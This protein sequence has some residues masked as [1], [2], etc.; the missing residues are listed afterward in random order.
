MRL[1]AHMKGNT[2]VNVWLTSHGDYPTDHYDYEQ[3]LQ[4]MQ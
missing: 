2:V 3:D 1:D 4:S